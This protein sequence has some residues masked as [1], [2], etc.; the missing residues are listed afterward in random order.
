MSSEPEQVISE[1]KH[2][3]C[4]KRASLKLDM[5]EA[6]E[7]CKSMLRARA[8]TDAGNSAAMATELEVILE[9]GT[10]LKNKLSEVKIW[11][12]SGAVRFW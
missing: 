7:C 3:I 9:Y 11:R 5:I 1:A 6:V 12:T 4:D 2:T 8:F 10:E